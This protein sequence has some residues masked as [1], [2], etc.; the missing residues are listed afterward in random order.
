[1]RPPVRRRNP[2]SA[3]SPGQRNGLD[4]VGVG[5]PGPLRRGDR[6]ESIQPICQQN[7]PPNNPMSRSSQGR[8]VSRLQ[9]RAPSM[10]TRP[11]GDGRAPPLRVPGVDQGRDHRLNAPLRALSWVSSSPRASP[12]GTAV[13]ERGPAGR[14][15]Q[16]IGASAFQAPGPARQLAIRHAGDQQASG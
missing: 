7:Q 8:R 13:F 9:A 6:Q 5:A 15:G 11:A 2:I 10:I 14:S 4:R 12:R 3:A 16:S 1:L